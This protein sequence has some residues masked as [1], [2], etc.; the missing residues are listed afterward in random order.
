MKIIYTIK[1]CFCCYLLCVLHVF[2]C[3]RMCVAVCLF[4]CIC[5]FWLL[6]LYAQS[7]NVSNCRQGIC[8]VFACDKLLQLAYLNIFSNTHFLTFMTSPHVFKCLLWQKHS[9]CIKGRLLWGAYPMFLCFCVLVFF[10]LFFALAAGWSS[11][12]KSLSSEINLPE[13]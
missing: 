7:L 10:F 12:L 3:L 5:V 6:N 13:N 4:I 9:D 2:I 8:V 1:R 11:T